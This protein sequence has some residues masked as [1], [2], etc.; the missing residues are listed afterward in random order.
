VL[1]GITLKDAMEQQKSMKKV[2]VQR[3]LKHHVML[4]K[5]VPH[6]AE[7]N[8][9]IQRVH[10]VVYFLTTQQLYQNVS[11]FATR[12]FTRQ[13]RSVSHAQ[14]QRMIAISNTM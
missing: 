7:V 6:V 3:A 2:C 8:M 5:P 1:R 9:K 4:E 12:D 14:Q 11:G 13:V 10:N